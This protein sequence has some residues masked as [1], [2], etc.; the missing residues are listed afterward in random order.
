VTIAIPTN[1]A[2]SG[3]R[4]LQLDP[5]GNRNLIADFATIENPARKTTIIGLN[6]GYM[7]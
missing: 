5:T 1:A 2:E 7:S 3:I 4:D 6:E